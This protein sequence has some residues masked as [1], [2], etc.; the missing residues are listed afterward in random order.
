MPLEDYDTKRDFSQTPEPRP[1]VRSSRGGNAFV[2]QKHAARRLHYDVRLELDGALKSWAVPKGPSLDPADKRLAVHVEDHPLDYAAFEGIIP[3]GEY[4]GGT[5]IVWDRGRWYP[6]GEAASDPSAAY[7]DGKLKF[8]LEGEKLR[9]AWML[10]RLAGKRDENKDNWLLFKERDEEARRGD[11]AAVT[12]LLP[13]SVASGRSLEDIA[14][15]DRERTAADTLSDGSERL[16]PSALPGARRAAGPARVD[17]ELATLVSQSPEGDGWL[18]E[19]KFDGYRVMCRLE[20]GVAQMLT[21]RGADW[22]THFPTLLA[23]VQRISA[24]TAL[25]DGEVVYVKP[26]GRTSFLRLASSL[27][28]GKDV[29]GRI[30][31]YVFDLLY[32]DGHDLTRVPLFRRKEALRRLLAGFAGPD[33]VRYVEHV[34]GSG[35]AFFAQACEFALEGEIA[36][37]RDS[38]Y[39]PGRGRDWLKVK[40]MHRQEFVIGGFSER[41][42]RRGGIGALLLGFRRGIDE[43]LLYAGRVGTGWDELSATDL[44]ERLDEL[45]AQSSPFTDFS[46]GKREAGVTWVRPE[47][48]VEVEYLSWNERGMFRHASFEGLR[49]D[50]LASEVVAEHDQGNPLKPFAPPAEA[51]TPPKEEVADRDESSPSADGGNG[52][53][54]EAPGPAT[55]PS[56]DGKRARRRGRGV[57]VG[58]V[59]ISNPERVMYPE[60]GLTKL[61]LARYY[62][63]I[64]TWMLPHVGRRPLTMVRCPEGHGESCFFQ[65]HAV[66]Q[67]PETILRVPIKEENATA[68]YVAIDSAAGLLTLV[69][70]GVLEFHVWGSHMETV[71]YP[72]QVVFDFDP[73]PS[74]PFAKVVDGARGMRAVLEE[75]GL[76]SFV[77]TTGG[78][79]LHVVVPL[80]P[81][82][83]WDEVKPVTKAIAEALVRSDPSAYVATMS[84]KKRTGK[85]FVDYLRN[86]RGATYISAFSTRRRP[87]APVATPLRWDELGPDLRAD[88]YGVGNV[89]RRLSRLRDDPWRGYDDVRQEMP[90]A[91][92]RAASAMFALRG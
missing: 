74:L 49:L 84:L 25:L 80:L 48:V 44:R 24:Q 62:E 67:F 16:D 46:G 86:G 77:K 65:K 66:D 55:S 41:A 36:K 90:P 61:D 64:A 13:D 3:K 14:Q 33:R 31:Y 8:R 81:A 60:L 72:D 42:D 56:A 17:P 7:R 92:Q 10:L 58:G 57:T 29:E 28:S 76:Q 35:D 37:R 68:T 23:S 19:I 78:K 39:R 52:P 1:V 18:H 2:I 11:A 32:L 47:L 71:E 75:L 91:M 40:C 73:D 69:Q 45:R 20:N 21:R 43:P 6:E 59:A 5:V 9:G 79:G 34:R 27:Q 4:G 15:G 54:A 83:R 53:E 30:V 70:M 88:R 38:L 87:G 85:I 22:T 26:D 63:D 82:Y 51:L 12:V 50:K 89:R